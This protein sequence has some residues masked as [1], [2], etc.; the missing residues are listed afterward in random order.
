MSSRARLARLA[1]TSPRLVPVTCVA[2]GSQGDQKLF[3]LKLSLPFSRARA[4]RRSRAAIRFDSFSIRDSILGFLDF[5]RVSGGLGRLWDVGTWSSSEVSTFLRQVCTALR[6][7]WSKIFKIWTRTRCLARSR[8]AS[9]W[10][11]LASCCSACAYRREP[12]F[13]F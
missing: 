4:A 10:R 2:R 7:T 12:L 1:S 3:F 11:S 9:I 13:P 5:S 6:T 8:L